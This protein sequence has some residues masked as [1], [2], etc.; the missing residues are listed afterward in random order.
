MGATRGYVLVVEDDTGSGGDVADVLDEAG[1]DVVRVS[2][3][4]DALAFL[5]R[6]RGRCV[7]LLDLGACD[8]DGWGTLSTIRAARHAVIV[9]SGR[10]EER[11][12]RGVPAIRR[13]CTAR[14]L[15]DAVASA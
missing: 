3:G 13:P 9:M 7:V 6:F 2:S 14:E 15:L 8:E 12:P 10:P 5:G 1:H 4:A 11:L